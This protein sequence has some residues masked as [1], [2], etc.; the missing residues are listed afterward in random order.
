MMQVVHNLS[1]KQPECLQRAFAC[2]W[3]TTHHNRFQQLPAARCG[4]GES[5]RAKRGDSSMVVIYRPNIIYY[6]NHYLFSETQPSMFAISYN[7]CTLAGFKQMHTEASQYNHSQLQWES[8]L[9]V[10]RKT[11]E[12]G[13][14]LYLHLQSVAGNVNQHDFLILNMCCSHCGWMHCR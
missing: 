9:G 5:D 12:R 10:T 13:T 6:L 14:P 11:W 2:S 7:C 8:K 1:V 3:Q 4:R